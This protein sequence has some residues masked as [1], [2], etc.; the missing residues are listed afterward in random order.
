MLAQETSLDSL[1][2]EDLSLLVAEARSTGLLGRMVHIAQSAQHS[3][4]FPPRF[5]DAISAAAIYSEGFARDVRR[6]TVF[7]E[8]ALAGLDMPVI[9]LKGAS[10]ILFGLPA[11][12]GRT[13]SD[14]DILVDKGHIAKVEAALML[15]GWSTG[16][17]SAYDQRYYRQWSHEIPPMTHLRR[18]TTVDLHHSLL[19][20]TCRIKVNS[21]TMVSEAV[22]DSSSAFWWRLNDEDIVLHSACH[23]LTN[24]EFDRGLRDLWDIDLLF[25]HFCSNTANFP[26]R[27]IERAKIVGLESIIARA[28][29]LARCVFNTPVPA[30]LLPGRA[31]TV[32]RL[33]SISASTRHPE[34]KPAGQHFADLV[35]LFRELFLRLPA[36]LLTVHLLHKAVASV[37]PSSRKTAV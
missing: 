23:L 37:V 29:W 12:K 33:L 31:G 28:L 18:G 17:L 15:G 21:A 8:Q 36:G 19:M 9:L 4:S 16:K 5:I 24:S 34:T 7:L 1:G 35:L 26:E 22:R 10:Y 27:L 32:T 30:A 13:F 11:G 25:R 14:I 2:P 6:E 20:P 3:S